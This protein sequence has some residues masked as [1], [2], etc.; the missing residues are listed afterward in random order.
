MQI[1]TKVSQRASDWNRGPARLLIYSGSWT[2]QR[3]VLDEVVTIGRGA[4]GIVHIDDEAMSREHVRIELSR[5]GNRFAITDLNSRN[6]TFLDGSPLTSAAL[7]HGSVVRMGETVAIADLSSPAAPDDTP[8]PYEHQLNERLEQWKESQAHT[9]V[10]GE[11]GVGK[12]RIANMI[13]GSGTSAAPPIVH[14]AGTTDEAV[15]QVID[16]FTEQQMSTGKEAPIVVILSRV[17]QLEPGAQRALLSRLDAAESGQMAPLRC[18][19]IASERMLA[20]V[21]GGLF[22][23][24]LYHRLAHSVVELAP[25]RDRPGDVCH[26]LGEQLYDLTPSA[27]LLEAI[28]LYDWPGNFQELRAVADH[29]RTSAVGEILHAN[30]LPGPLR[31]VFVRDGQPEFDGRPTAPTPAPNTTATISGPILVKPSRENLQTWLLACDGNV[32]ELARQMDKHRNQ[33]V[34]WLRSYKLPTGHIDFPAWQ[35]EVTM[36]S[37]GIPDE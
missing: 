21:N 29:L 11:P 37:K 16:G 9:M 6:G 34:R 12:R 32:S 13:G 18:I 8:S 26:Y 31:S 10:I 27:D 17:E 3:V 20:L 28:A 19:S 36:R 4:E 25:L 14:C 33:V 22:D 23:R 2:P 30:I 7:R 24:S 1:T 35:R 15:S 5:A